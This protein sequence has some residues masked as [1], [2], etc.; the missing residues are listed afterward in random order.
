MR[1]F[2]L[3]LVL[4]LGWISPLAAQTQPVQTLTLWNGHSLEHLQ[5]ELDRFTK[6]TGFQVVQQHF[7]ADQF[8]DKVMSSVLLPDL[9]F[10]PSDQISNQ[11]EYHLGA[12]PESIAADFGLR[13]DGRLHGIWY[14]IPI[15]MGNQL[16]F[17]Y[18]KDK[19][20]PALSIEAIPDKQL[21]WPR[22]QA[23]WFMTFLTANGGWPLQDDRFTLNTPSMVAALQQYKK[24]IAR[25]PA[26][27]CELL[28]NEQAFIKGDVS[29]LM[30][31]DWAYQMLHDVLGDKLGV[32]LLPT[33]GG[34]PMTPLSSS[35][36]LAFRADISPAKR[37]AAVELARFLLSDRSQHSL[38]E[39]SN[40]FPAVSHVITQLGSKMSSDMKTMHQQLLLSKAMPNDRKMLIVWL[41]MGK[42]LKL[43]LAG[44]YDAVEAA[45]NMQ[46]MAEEEGRQQ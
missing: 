28:C 37:Q 23:F 22:E 8:R 25:F 41:V 38:Y 15:N 11:Q 3:L 14:G 36:V 30:D 5:P 17:Y 4:S 44:E 24:E 29:Y 31:G 19:V 45:Q 33:L 21:A 7:R 32:A 9:Y 12:W 46:S 2:H 1:L 10:I 6:A 42:T 35:Y 27:D 13:E 39:R 34:N 26:S 16:M 20:K 18:R 43:F 40:L